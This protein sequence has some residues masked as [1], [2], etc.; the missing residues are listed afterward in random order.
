MAP[1][2]Y[3]YMFVPSG[4][5]ITEFTSIQVLFMKLMKFTLLHTL[6]TFQLQVQNIFYLLLVAFLLFSI[7]VHLPLLFRSNVFKYVF[8]KVFLLQCFVQTFLTYTQL[9]KNIY[10]DS[11]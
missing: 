5:I 2:F 1:Q 6:Q 10:D 9:N 7:R 11:V 3:Y 8:K 4:V